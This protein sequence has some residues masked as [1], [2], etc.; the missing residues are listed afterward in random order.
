[1]SEVAKVESF[2]RNPVSMAERQPIAAGL[3]LTV[4]LVAV[5]AVKSGRQ[6]AK[7]Q[8]VAAAVGAGAFVAVAKVAP[9]PVAWLALLAIAYTVVRTPDGL[10]DFIAP[11]AAR[12]GVRI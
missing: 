7:R 3:L 4:G 11:Y 9:E 8:I 1:M 2:A 5:A 12:I 10:A 6:P